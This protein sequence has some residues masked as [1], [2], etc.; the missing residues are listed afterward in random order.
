MESDQRWFLPDIT[1]KIRRKWDDRGYQF[2]IAFDEMQRP[3][4]TFQL[5][6]GSNILL[7]RLVYGETLSSP[8]INNNRL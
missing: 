7:E 2:H 3:V 5:N 6:S 1:G 8:E 4:Q